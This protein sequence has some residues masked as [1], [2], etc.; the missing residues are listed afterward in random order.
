MPAVVGRCIQD[1]RVYEEATVRSRSPS[2]AAPP[3]SVWQPA[4]KTYRALVVGCLLCSPCGQQSCSSFR[5]P[6]HS[7]R[8]L[9]RCITWDNASRVSSVVFLSVLVADACHRAASATAAR[10]VFCLLSLVYWTASSR[11]RVLAVGGCSHRDP[12]GTLCGPC[13]GPVAPLRLL[14]LID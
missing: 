9:T 5:L 1:A 2:S 11:L 10:C 13:R 3:G 6:Q 7:T 8:P 12:V 4:D 14:L